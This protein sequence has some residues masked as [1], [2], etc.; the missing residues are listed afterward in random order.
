[1]RIQQNSRKVN[2]VN[3]ATTTNGGAAHGRGAAGCRHTQTVSKRLHQGSGGAIKFRLGTL[4]V[5][6]L[7]GKSG[8]VVETL[9][10]RRLDLC[11]LQ[12]VRWKGGHSRTVMGKD[13]HYKFFWQGDREGRAGVGIAIAEKWVDKVVRVD[14]VSDRII[15][16]ELLIGKT[17]TTFISVYAPQVNLKDPEKDSFY[18]ALMATVAKVD[19]KKLL[20]IAGD[21]NGHVGRSSEGYEGIHGGR[22]YG[23]R[24]KEGDRILEFGNATDMVVLNTMFDKRDSRLITYQSGGH[25][26]QIDYILIGKKHRKLVQ[27]VNA[28][29]GEEIAQQHRLVIGDLCIESPREAK[30]NFV[31]RR[32]TWKLKNGH[33]ASAFQTQFSKL[34][35]GWRE[36]PSKLAEEGI[37]GQTV[38]GKWSRLKD[39]LLL[40]AEK[41]C[42][43][44]KGP[45]KRHVTWWWNKE[46]DN[47]LRRLFFKWKF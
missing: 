40:A 5:G 7:R 47:A 44:T 27:D 13:S 42:G 12:E 21:L 28:I 20:I 41:T 39:N 10:R 16:L 36:K 29:A 32:K 38:Q 35:K 37:E 15:A 24:N 19:D 8:E 18:E 26:T 11:C 9:T 3:G 43:W 4:N 14:R 46:V 23:N 25:S 1:M 45:S 33:I 6:T 30:K 17:V 31:P 22:G 2:C 34:A